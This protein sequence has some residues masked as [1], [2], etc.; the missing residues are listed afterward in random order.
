MTHTKPNPSRLGGRR[1]Y[2]VVVLVG[3]CIHKPPTAIDSPDPRFAPEY[4]RK[5]HTHAGGKENNDSDSPP[6]TFLDSS[7]QPPLFVQPQRAG[8]TCNCL[9][10][11]VFPKNLSILRAANISAASSGI[12]QPSPLIIPTR[13]ERNATLINCPSAQL[14]IIICHR[15]PPPPT[16]PSFFF[17][18]TKMNLNFT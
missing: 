17:F 1:G 16:D 9:A 14:P 18:I 13:C 6:W 5:V 12:L 7:H 3:G 15:T 8:A 11:F 2:A 4:F 10:R